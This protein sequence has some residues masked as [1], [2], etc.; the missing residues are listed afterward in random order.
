MANRE[1]V[2]MKQARPG[3]FVWLSL[4]T[5]ALRTYLMNILSHSRGMYIRSVGFQTC[6]T[7]ANYKL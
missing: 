4:R 7:L 2:I 1:P 5:L 3:S 6:L